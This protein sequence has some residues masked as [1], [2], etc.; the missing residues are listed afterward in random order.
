MQSNKNKYV[1]I[2]N[3]LKQFTYD[4]SINAKNLKDLGYIV[5]SLIKDATEIV[6]KR[7]KNIPEDSHLKS[8]FGGQPYFEKG[9]QWPTK[10]GSD[11]FEFIFQIF[12]TGNINLPENIK[13]VQFYYD[14]ENYPYDES[15]FIKIYEQIN[16][17][18]NIVIKKPE[19][20]S[21]KNYCEIEYVAK[22][23][24]PDI[25][26]GID[27]ATIY[28]QIV[29]NLN[30]DFNFCSQLG[31]Y[32][33]KLQTEAS[34]KNKDFQLLF[35]IDS[36]S[37]AGLMWSDCGLVYAFYNKKTKETIFDIRFC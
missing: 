16:V 9:E 17:A 29:K 15:A 18:N 36:E 22:K 12:N 32:P 6:P 27:E 7:K 33:K 5:K 14:F 26:L 8:H 19:W 13:L 21:E 20:H 10:N 2:V 28:Y 25:D 30:V 4:R 35:Q 24:L 23:S 31:G 37:E 11:N 1:E 3:E 34:P